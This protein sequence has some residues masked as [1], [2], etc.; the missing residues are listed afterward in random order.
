MPWPFKSAPYQEEQLGTLTRSGGY[1]N[2][3]CT[4][5][6]FGAVRLKISGDRTAPEDTG[7]ALA[8]ELPARFRGSLR[9]EIGASLFEHLQPYQE[10]TGAFPEIRRGNDV[11]PYVRPI[12]VLI[13]R[14]Q[15]VPTIDLALS[16]AWDEEHTLGARIQAWKLIELCG[17]VL[18]G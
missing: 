8:R 3:E 12:Q 15:G 13:E 10:E 7:L 18:L 9:D 2:G 4:L 11:W 16:V 6:G 17:S 5:P 14:Q 1:W